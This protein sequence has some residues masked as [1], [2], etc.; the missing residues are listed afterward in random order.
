M[1]SVESSAA[2]SCAK[3]SKS[4]AVIAWMSYMIQRLFIPPSQVVA[5]ATRLSITGDPS[6]SFVRTCEDLGGRG[7]GLAEAEAEEA[8]IK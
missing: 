2:R 3:S 8:Q 7:A 6:N 4:S 1:S 5:K